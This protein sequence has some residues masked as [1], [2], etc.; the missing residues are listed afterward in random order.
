VKLVIHSEPEA[1]SQASSTCLSEESTEQLTINDMAH[2]TAFAIPGQIGSLYRFFDKKTPSQ[3]WRLSWAMISFICARITSYRLFGHYL[4]CCLRQLDRLLFSPDQQ[5]NYVHKCGRIS[6]I[7]I[8]SPSL[9][10]AWSSAM[11]TVISSSTSGGVNDSFMIE[12]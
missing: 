6:L 1:S 3:R 8:F 11:T 2:P 7:S 10:S 4:S 9:T 12:V 5:K